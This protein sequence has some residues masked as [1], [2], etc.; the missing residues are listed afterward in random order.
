MVKNKIG[1]N[2]GY[3]KVIIVGYSI[4]IFLYGF[5]K[6]IKFIGFVGLESIWVVFILCMCLLSK[7]YKEFGVLFWN[8]VWL[9]FFLV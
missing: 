3:L 7:E 4:R 9:Y 2:I 5:N 8:F 6:D 1:Y